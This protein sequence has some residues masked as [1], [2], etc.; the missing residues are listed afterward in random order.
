[1]W[2]G[3]TV[4]S[5]RIRA[6]DACGWTEALGGHR[7][8]VWDNTPV[9]DA[10]MTNELHLGP[11][12]GRDPDLVDVVAGVLCNPM[13]QARASMLQLATTMEFLRDPD[14]YDASAAWG[15]AGQDLAGG[16]HAPLMVLARAC[17]DGPLI[18]PGSL[19]LSRLVDALEEKL[20]G[21]GWVDGRQHPR[22]RAAGGPGA[23]GELR[24]RRPAR[25]AG[26]RGRAL[27]R[28]RELA[29]DGRAG[30]AA[31][32]SAVQLDRRRRRRRPVPRDST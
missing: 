21:P 5:P 19:D 12:L 10:T 29:R 22:G 1:M 4:C 25:P 13:T 27:G 11:Y 7:T 30:G 16:R 26:R 23:A 18:E 9:N 15:R 17:A 28:C 3:P 20:A 31:P 24:D 14:G 32:D 2:T 6:E 8:I